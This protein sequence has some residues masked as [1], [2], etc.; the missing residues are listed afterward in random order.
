MEQRAFERLLRAFDKLFVATR[1]PLSFE[2]R[3]RLALRGELLAY[4]EARWITVHPNGDEHEGQPV[5]IDDEGGGRILGGMGGKFNGQKISEIKKGF[6]GP[7]SPD[8]ETL[9]KKQEE[10][11]KREEKKRQEEAQKKSKQ[12]NHSQPDFVQKALE[13]GGKVSVAQ[14]IRIIKNKEFKDYVDLV[15]MEELPTSLKD[16]MNDSI[17]RSNDF[18]KRGEDE[19]YFEE[20]EKLGVLVWGINT[21]LQKK[22]YQG[23]FKEM[24]QQELDAAK[25]TFSGFSGSQI[26][27]KLKSQSLKEIESTISQGPEHLQSLFGKYADRM[28]LR[29]TRASGKYY[30]GTFSFDVKTK[31]DDQDRAD[32]LAHFTFFHESGHLID[33]GGGFQPFSYTYRKNIFGDTLRKEGKAYIN[34]H[35]DEFKS[36]YNAGTLGKLLNGW[37]GNDKYVGS[38]E[39][40][41]NHVVEMVNRRSAPLLKTN[42][43]KKTICVLLGMQNLCT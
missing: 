27:S 43:L 11:H 29:S 21:M 42:E 23:K 39:D 14:K 19:K 26:A 37:W 40:Y 13:L 25:M 35:Y 12:D 10:Q 31:D 15:Y 18:A 8:A 2:E 33:F 1:K 20:Q 3:L 5:L 4:D 41:A 34:A 22:E 32:R 38:G 24:H 7:K 28:E 9:V 6:V 16:A 36:A 30:P 17:T